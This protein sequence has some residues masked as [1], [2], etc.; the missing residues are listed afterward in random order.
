MKERIWNDILN[1]IFP[2]VCHICGKPLAPHERF[3][4]SDCIAKL[5]RTGYHRKK[6]NPMEERFAGQFP[7]QAATGHFFYNR[8]SS[9]SILIQDMKYRNFPSIGNML[10]ELSAREL[11]S[12]GFLSD[13]EAIVPVPMH[14]L[15]RAKRGYNQ[16]DHIAQGIAKVIGVPVIPALKM[17]RRHKTQTNLTQTKRLLNSENL[18]ELKN[19]NP[20]KG[21]NI[22]L[23]DDVCTTGSTL[24]SA[25]K[26]ISDT[27]VVG[28]MSIFSVGVTF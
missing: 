14:F 26:V 3:A 27:G 7:F 28:G 11:L 12:S 17:I 20:I 4:C 15:K 19:I 25:G 21:K 8:D 1:V 22:L 10:G 6:M 13:I 23:V 16:T 5:P 2:S 9:L 18:F 24:R